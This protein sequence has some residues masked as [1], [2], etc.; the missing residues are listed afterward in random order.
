MREVY[1]FQYLLFVT[2][3]WGIAYC[4][5]EH[6]S[7]LKIAKAAAAYK[8]ST[9]LKQSWFFILFFTGRFWS[10]FFFYVSPACAS[11][12]SAS[13]FIK[14]PNSFSMLRWSRLYKSEKKKNMEKILEVR[15]SSIL[16]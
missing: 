12:L 2:G 4:Q 16:S 15:K 9:G 10:V 1:C 3:L 8:E 5:G 6:Y 11:V 13:H 7:K 14:M